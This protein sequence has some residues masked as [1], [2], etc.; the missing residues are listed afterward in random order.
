MIELSMYPAPQ[1]QNWEQ[2]VRNVKK[3]IRFCIIKAEVA[4]HEKK[5]DIQTRFQF[6]RTY[7]YKGLL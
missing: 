7:L 4:S 1:D 6:S 2:R 3:Y 5:Q